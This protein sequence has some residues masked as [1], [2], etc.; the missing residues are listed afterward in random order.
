MWT[1]GALSQRQRLRV[2]C[3]V[4]Y[5]SLLERKGEGKNSSAM[6]KSEA[7]MSSGSAEK[8]LI[9]TASLSA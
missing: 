3:L 9:H 2:I 8:W 5:L 1:R 7:L 4:S 6:A